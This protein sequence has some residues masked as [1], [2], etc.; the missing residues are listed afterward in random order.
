MDMVVVVNANI[1]CVARSY[2]AVNEGSMANP[3]PTKD[4]L[5][6]QLFGRR[7]SS[8]K[9]LMKYPMLKQLP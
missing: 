2:T 6:T 1:V 4:P 9:S 8:T 3:T 7:I 5:L